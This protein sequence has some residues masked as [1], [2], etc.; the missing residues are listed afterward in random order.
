MKKPMIFILATALAFVFGGTAL[1]QTTVELNVATGVSNVYWGPSFATT[2]AGASAFV[3]SG[4]ILTETT[5]KDVTGTS[6]YAI[7]NTLTSADGTEMLSQFLTFDSATTPIGGPQLLSGTSDTVIL[8]VMGPMTGGVGDGPDSGGTLYSIDGGTGTV[9]WTRPIAISGYTTSAQADEGGLFDSV[10]TGATPYVLA[11]VTID[12]ESID[13]SG[14]TIFG[15][16]GTTP[17]IIGDDNGAA[18]VSVWAIDS[19]TGGYAT[20]AA[21]NSNVTSF[22]VTDEYSGVSNVVAAP[23]ISGDSL[24]VL[25][26]SQTFSAITVFQFVKN[27]LLAGVSAHALVNGSAAVDL[28]D[29]WIPT[30]AVSGNSLFVVDNNGAVTSFYAANLTQNYASVDYAGN[31]TDS[32][33]TAGPVTNGTYIVLSAT[34]SVTAYRLDNLSGNSKEWTFDFGAPRSIWATPVISNGYVWV[35]VNDTAAGNATTY[36]FTLSDTYDGN[37]QIVKAHGNLIYASPIIVGNDLWT[38]TYNPLAEK[39]AQTDFAEGANWWTQ[40]KF[41]AAKTGDNTVEAAAPYTP[42]SSGGCFISTIK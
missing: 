24:F 20:T 35:T 34:S 31:S 14:A 40:F 15:V 32:G 5:T 3:L 17:V 26:Y 13:D 30:P 25:G 8:L 38:V 12:S 2:T 11:P 28:S 7:S 4:T 23:V 22:V 21:G 36:R 39:T 29:Q 1:A 33:V 19:D 37:P 6:L 18:G 9:Y 10:N 27:D 42:G 41:D 16:S